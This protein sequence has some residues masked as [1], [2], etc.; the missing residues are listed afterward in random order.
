MTRW[1]HLPDHIDQSRIHDPLSESK[2]GVRRVPRVS[3]EYMT[4]SAI[5][6]DVVRWAWSHEDERLHLLTHYPNEGRVLE[7]GVQRGYPDLFL[8][9]PVFSNGQFRQYHGYW[10]E[11]K[12]PGNDLTDSQYDMIRTLLRQGYATD[13]AWSVRQARFSISNYLHDPDSF[14]PGW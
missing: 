9:V 3:P 14:L 7:Y 13:V 8:P 2:G 11:L 5:Q 10:L 6:R 4:E 1:S 12:R